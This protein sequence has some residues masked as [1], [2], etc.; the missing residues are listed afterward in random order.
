MSRIGKLPIV[1]PKG[2]TVSFNEPELIVKGPKGELKRKIHPLIGLNTSATEIKVEPKDH[3]AADAN[4]LWGLFRSLINNMVTGVST[5]FSK[6]LEV[7]GVGWKIEKGDPQSLTNADFMADLKGIGVDPQTLKGRD[8]LKLSLGYSHLTI[9]LLPKG[10]TPIVDD[11][12]LWVTLNSVDN[13]LLGEACAKIR[14][15]RPPEPYKGKGIRYRGE[16]IRRK[17]G[18]A[19]AK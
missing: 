12:L 17:A 11:K 15:F 2:V 7:S 19:G 14:A 8:F 3:K 13:E 5:G 10:V 16:V 6:T 9:Y 4:A 18:K 1:I